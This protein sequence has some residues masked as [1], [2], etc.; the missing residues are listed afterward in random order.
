MLYAK[1]FGDGEPTIGVFGKP[2]PATFDYARDMLDRR[3][4][5]MGLS[6]NDGPLERIY[7]VG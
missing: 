6:E 4:E 3:K 7:M 5:A 1:R 2:T